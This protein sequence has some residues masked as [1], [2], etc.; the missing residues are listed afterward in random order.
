MGPQMR[1]GIYVSI[2]KIEGDEKQL[3]GDICWNKLSL[4]HLDP[5]TKQCDLGVQRIIHL[6]RLANRLPDA[7]T[8]PKR[9]TKSHI[10]AANAPIKISVLEGPSHIGN[11]SNALLKHGRP[12]GSKDKNP[13]KKKGANSEHSQIEIVVMPEKES[14]KETLDMMVQD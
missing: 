10:P 5:Q 9:V 1:L 8:D 12:I 3:N 4:S 14:A 11:E 2:S 6:Q 7:F 13:Q